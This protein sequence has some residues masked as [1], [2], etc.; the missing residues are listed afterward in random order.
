MWKQ[1][2]RVSIPVLSGDKWT[3]GSWK[4]AFMACV[5]KAPA[6]LEYKLLQLKKYLSGEALKAVE[7]LGHLA[8]AYEAAQS[9]LERK[10]KGQRR[11]INLYMVELDQFRPIRASFG[12]QSVDGRT[13]TRV[14][15]F[16]TTRMNRDMRP[17]DWKVQATKWKHLQGI[18]FPYLGPRPIV[19]M[20]IG[21]DYAE[22]HYSIK[23]IRGQPGES[24]A[25]QTPL[26]WTCIGAADVVDGSSPCTNLNVAYFVHPEM[27][28]LTSVLQ[29][30]WEIETS[31]SELKRERESETGRR[32]SHQK[33]LKLSSVQE[34]KI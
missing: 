8:E 9:R 12:M 29:K 22:L 24:V 3:Y 11:Q 4:A 32:F 25:R 26:G 7:S 19:D 18:N 31:D 23:G 10:Y 21:I 13:S 34:W 30:L 16:T 15:A 28:E 20:L 27:K 17:I 2:K 6:T 1:L 33:I 5:D 14:S